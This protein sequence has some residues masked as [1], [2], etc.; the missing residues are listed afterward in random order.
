MTNISI[1]P[2]Q[3]EEQLDALFNL[4]MYA[5]ANCHSLTNVILPERLVTMAKAMLGKL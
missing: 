1:R 3:G 5:F 4:G 2:L